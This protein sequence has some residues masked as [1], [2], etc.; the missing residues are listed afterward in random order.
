MKALEK[1][2]VTSRHSYGIL[3]LVRAGGRSVCKMGKTL[4][5]DAALLAKSLAGKTVIVT[6]GNAGETFLR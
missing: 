6:G 2:Q 4:M 5:C 3:I 1:F